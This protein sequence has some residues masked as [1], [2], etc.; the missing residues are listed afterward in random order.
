MQNRM[1]GETVMM[2]V[3][4]E[5]EEKVVKIV[6]EAIEHEVFML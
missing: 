2:Q 4:R 6:M 5:C 1:T 3:G